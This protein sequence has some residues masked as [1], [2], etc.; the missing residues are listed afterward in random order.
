MV[1]ADLVRLVL[2]GTLAVW[3][4]EVIVVYAVGAFV[5]PFLLTRLSG[6][7]RRPRVVFIAFGLRGAVDVV[8]ATLTALPATL[9]ALV[10]YGLGTST[11][12][13]T[14]ASVIQSHVPADLR[15][16][17]CAAFDLIW[18]SMR[19]VSLLVGGL[20]ADSL[21]I[22]AVY[23]AGGVLLFAAAAAGLSLARR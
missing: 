10:F 22:Q 18:H 20:L 21:G 8:V 15:G 13:V 23:Y 9:A 1:G 12:N 4:S 17:V 16:R 5:G 2:A 7:A 11:G 6:Q 19:L 14:F 3:H